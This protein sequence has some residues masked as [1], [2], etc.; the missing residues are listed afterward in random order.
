MPF[1]SSGQPIEG[2][3][4]F[5]AI[6]K[7]VTRVYIINNEG[8]TVIGCD[9]IVFDTLVK[10]GSATIE[11]REDHNATIGDLNVIGVPKMQ[12]FVERAPSLNG[13]DIS[14]CFTA[15]VLPCDVLDVPGESTVEGILQALA[16][17][18][19]MKIVIVRGR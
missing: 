10:V 13:L 4:T 15:T 8:H 9:S 16:G 3:R 5:N 12:I 7:R 2:R 11:V 18:I 6:S 14:Q 17:L 19:T 1:S